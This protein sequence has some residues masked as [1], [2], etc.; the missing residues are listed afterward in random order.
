[1]KNKIVTCVLNN[2]QLY[3]DSFKREKI[4]TGKAY[5]CV[6]ELILTSH[7]Y[8]IPEF[9]SLQGITIRSRTDKWG[10]SK[11]CLPKECFR[12][13]T[14]KEIKKYKVLFLINTPFRIFKKFFFKIY[15][16]VDRIIRWK[17]F[18]ELEKHYEDYY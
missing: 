13:S 14:E 8:Y 2:H 6:D 18:K 4:K 10:W 12:L 15:H 16:K 5:K 7:G 3:N 1:M 11:P 17:Y 9:A